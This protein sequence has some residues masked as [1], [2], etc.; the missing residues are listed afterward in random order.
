MAIQKILS[1]MRRAIVDYNMIDDGDKIVVGLS[2]GKDSLILLTALRNYQIF[3]PQKFE[4][5][6]VTVDLGLGADFSHLIKYCSDIDVPFHIEHTEIANI[7]FNE[8]KEKSPCSLCSKMRRGTL[9]SCV[10]DFKFNKLALGHHA[11]DLVE[12]M[13]LSLFYEGRLSTFAAKSYMDRTGVTLIRPLILTFEKDIAAE[14]ANLPVLHNPCPVNHATKREYMKTLI[15]N[16]T[17]DI[18]FAKERMHSAIIS[19]DRYNLFDKPFDNTPLKDKDL[20]E[21]L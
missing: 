16:I 10:N 14:S 9:N 19:P 8:R 17:K 12:T 5:K 13:L 18:P 20:D 21:I 3:S 7:I 11:D 15:S 4:L 1:S 6:A 2:G